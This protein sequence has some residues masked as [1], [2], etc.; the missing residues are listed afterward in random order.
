MGGTFTSKKAGV[1]FSHKYSQCVD[2]VND[3]VND[4]S[5]A[6]EPISSSTEFPTEFDCGKSWNTKDNISFVL[7]TLK[8]SAR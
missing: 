8:I 5:S 3:P 6:V 2:S 1:R 4:F 7:V